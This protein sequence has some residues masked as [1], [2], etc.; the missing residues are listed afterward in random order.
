[1]FSKLETGRMPSLQEVYKVLEET[2]HLVPA[3]AAFAAQ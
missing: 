2:H 1:M 3:S